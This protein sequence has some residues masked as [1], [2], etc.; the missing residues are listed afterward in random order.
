MDAVK[1]IAID[2]VNITD[3]L[4]SKYVRL[5]AEKIIPYQWEALN[6]RI[7]NMEKSHCLDNFRVAAGDQQGRHQGAIFQDTDLYKWLEA[8]AFCIANGTGRQL[9]PLADEAVELIG[10][11]QQPD[12][13]LNT[14]ITIECP[15]NRWK[16]LAEGHEL[17]GAGH[18]I[19]AAVAYY[20]ATGKEAILTI[21][22][23]FADRIDETF[24]DEDGKWHGH[25]G[26][27]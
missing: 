20:N 6:D 7:P 9:I 21:A 17:Y 26:H 15:E 23:R 8:V 12:G 11:A 3:P 4:F 22:R 16:N 13:Y 18:L 1:P 24:G 5:V 14:Y 27:Q 10:R 19:E 25:P 2:Q